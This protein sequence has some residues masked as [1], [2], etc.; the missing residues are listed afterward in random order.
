MKVELRKGK[1]ISIKCP[2][3]GNKTFEDLG[4]F[5]EDPYEDTDFRI[6]CNQCTHVLS[7]FAPVRLIEED[8]DL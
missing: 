5:G 3:C 2:I 6:S 4:D 1:I 8:G 7:F